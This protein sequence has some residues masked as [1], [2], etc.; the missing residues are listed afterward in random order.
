MLDGVRTFD[1]PTSTHPLD[2]EIILPPSPGPNNGRVVLDGYDDAVVIPHDKIDF[3]EGP[4]TRR[5]EAQG[6]NDHRHPRVR[7]Q[8]RTVGVRLVRTDGV[9]EFWVMTGGE[10]LVA[11]SESMTL[12]AN[13]EYHLAGVWDGEEAR[14][15]VNGE[16]AGRAAG[17]GPR[18]AMNFHW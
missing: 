16:L 2:V 3:E 14:L 10:Y 15:Y 13:E 18:R 9:P 11:G 6:P 1:I 8:G 12:Q 17:E 5:G 4:F 7:H